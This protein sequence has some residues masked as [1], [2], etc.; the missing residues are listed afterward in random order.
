[1]PLGRTANR[2]GEGE[3]EGGDDSPATLH[4]SHRF[5]VVEFSG[6]RRQQ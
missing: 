1:M 5:A 3:R 4:L 2:T 6:F